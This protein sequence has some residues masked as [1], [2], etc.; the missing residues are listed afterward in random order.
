MSEVKEDSKNVDN[1]NKALVV[2]IKDGYDWSVY[3]EQL[4]ID[5]MSN[6]ALVAEVSE[7]YWSEESDPKGNGIEEDDDEYDWRDKSDPIVDIQAKEVIQ[8]EEVNLSSKKNPSKSGGSTSDDSSSYGFNNPEFIKWQKEMLK[9]K[10]HSEVQSQ[11]INLSP[12]VSKNST[13]NPKSKSKQNQ[14]RINDSCEIPKTY[15][16]RD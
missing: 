1:P 6:P 9:Q 10:E 16:H 3:A 13:R 15:Y 8:T 2:S 5:V 12:S 7:E 11:S 14:K 4:T